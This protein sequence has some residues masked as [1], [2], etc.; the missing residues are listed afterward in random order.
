MR[1]ISDNGDDEVDVSDKIVQWPIM[2]TNWTNFTCWTL[3]VSWYRCPELH[4]V[5]PSSSCFFGFSYGLSRSQIVCSQLCL[6]R[7][8]TKIWGMNLPVPVRINV[9]KQRLWAS[10]SC[11]QC[12]LH[13]IWIHYHSET[14]KIGVKEIG[15]FQRMM[16]NDLEVIGNITMGTF[17]AQIF[18][19]HN[20]VL[21]GNN[22]DHRDSDEVNIRR[23]QIECRGGSTSKVV[24]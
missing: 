11:T 22:E 19:C 4:W 9:K 6:G 12:E 18:L 3:A 2:N 8:I 10:R 23:C 24:F 17:K 13:T 20:W 15:W 1:I 5:I 16:I 14:R 21:P 7:K